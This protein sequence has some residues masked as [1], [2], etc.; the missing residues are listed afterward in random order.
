MR[1]RAAFVGRNDVRSVLIDEYANNENNCGTVAFCN[2]GDHPVGFS[3][4]IRIVAP[5][6]CRLVDQPA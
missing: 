5:T 3:R 1:V 4:I 6:R 2:F